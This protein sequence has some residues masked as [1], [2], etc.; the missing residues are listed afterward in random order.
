MLRTRQAWLALCLLTCSLPL[1]AARET[2]LNLPRGARV[3]IVNLLDPEVTHYHIARALQ[4]EFMKTHF[5]Y[6]QV[7]SMLTEALRDGLAHKGLVPVP[8]VVDAALIRNLQDCLL[9]AN[10]A[11]DLPK[12]CAAPF[13]EMATSR[14][15]DA[16][17]V[18]APGLN[19]SDHAAHIRRKDLPEDLRGWGF[20]TDDSQAQANPSLF[21]F[22]ELLVI[23][24]AA[25]GP[26]LRG[27]EWGGSYTHEW[28]D[29]GLPPNLK[30]IPRQQ[31]D[32]LQPLFSALL[33]DQVTGLLQQLGEGRATVG[34]R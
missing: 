3:G 2:P 32:R 29:F 34:A 1:L 18:L 8:L 26:S 10:L 30:A 28:T 17:I 5:V 9:H 19:N 13:G 7:D 21:N 15:V 22:T 23:G 6:W 31:M 14:G 25:D 12:K 33:A 20:V 27:R 4:D 11:K 16:F 24:M